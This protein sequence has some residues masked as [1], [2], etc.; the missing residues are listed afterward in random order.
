VSTPPTPA[1]YR[2]RRLPDL[3]ASAALLVAAG[4]ELRAYVRAARPNLV[5]SAYDIYSYF[6]P[7]MLYARDRLLHHGGR[8]LLW[9]PFQNAGQ[10]FIGSGVTGILYPPSAFFLLFEPDRALHALLFTNMAIGALG[11]YVLGRELGVGR[12]AALAGGLA[13]AFS[14]AAID[15]I[16][17][18]PIVSGPYAWLPWALALCE[19]ILRAPSA[20]AAIGLGVVLTLALLPG[21]P[22]GLVYTYQVIA[23]RILWEMLVRRS[24]LGVRALAALGAAL[25]IPP[26]LGA[27]HLLP[28][29]EMMRLSVRGGGLDLTEISSGTV[30]DWWVLRRAFTFR[31][32][33]FNPLPVMPFVL[34]SAALANR[35][36][37]R[38]VWFYVVVAVASVDLALGTKGHLFPLAQELPLARLFRGPDRYLWITHFAVAV[39][40][41][42][43]VDALLGP[44]P[45]GGSTVRWATVP[46]AAA[47]L[48]AAYLFSLKGLYRPEW[49]GGGV[50]V[51]AAVGALLVPRFAPVAGLLVV[52]ALVA[53]LLV[54]R[55]PPLRS[56]LLDGRELYARG[57]VFTDLRARM[58]AQERAYLVPEHARFALQHKT[59]SLF[60]VPTLF[61]YES[62]PSRR[63]S[64][65]FTM[66]RTGAH[67]RGLID[68]YYP[69]AGWL[70]P[71][72]RRPLLDLAAARWVV[73]AEKADTTARLA[74][75]ALVPIAARD[76]VRVYQNPTALPRARWVGQVQVVADDRLALERLAAARLDP[77]RAAVVQ[78]PPPSGFLGADVR[79]AGRVTF[80]L[81]DPEHVV[82]DVDA[83]ARGFV[84]LADQDLPG[85]HA[86]VNGTPVPILRGDYVF[87]LVEVPAGRSTVEFRYRPRPLFTGA[88]VSGV[89]LVVLV[90]V[91]VRRRAPAELA[92]PHGERAAARV[93]A[94]RR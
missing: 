4:Y 13:F 73:A 51:V 34:A 19:R 87:R 39:L 11:A 33:L 29:L 45:A 44:R 46:L 30:L 94:D 37:W 36:R 52:G 61:D 6:Y 68:V 38:S 27:V 66:L 47:G 80:A 23:L 7:V 18:T 92:L 35:L 53:E 62:L 16:S 10:P 50:I 24:W 26:L 25:V 57:A 72:A 60:A 43:G 20:R 3:L 55:P 40:A 28:A 69:L 2:T 89:T 48:L 93:A 58:T 90:L 63:W 17:F 31:R 74:G 71:T 85:W 1:A 76:G 86:T 8:G 54:L 78:A 21:H 79:D 15:L 83:P 88:L 65:Y 49:T 84:V 67:M 9:N 64:E 59:G 41:A 91:L 81:D 75:A 22:Q 82:L 14:H 56:L 70:P 77:R 5:V 32:E 42:L 12:I